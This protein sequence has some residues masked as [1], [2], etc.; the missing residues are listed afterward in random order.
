M[1][2]GRAHTRLGQERERLTQLVLHR[3]VRLEQEG[4]TRDVYSRH[5]AYVLTEEYRS[6][7]D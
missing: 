6:L 1:A 2:A 7:P 5:L 4:V 3:W